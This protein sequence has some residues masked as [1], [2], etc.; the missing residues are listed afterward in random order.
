MAAGLVLAEDPMTV[1]AR[2]LK[3]YV[4]PGASSM[5]LLGDDARPFQAPARIPFKTL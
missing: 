1:Q 5:A 2:M 4:A 3:L